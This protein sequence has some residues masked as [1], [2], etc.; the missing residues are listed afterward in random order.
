[1]VR[2][3]EEIHLREHAHHLA[4]TN[5]FFLML[6]AIPQIFYEPRTA[7]KQQLRR[8]QL[9]V[10]YAVIQQL[11]VKFG[12]CDMVSHKI[13]RLMADAQSNQNAGKDFVSDDIFF[14][15]LKALFPFPIDL[16]PNLDLIIDDGLGSHGDNFDF[17]DAFLFE[18]SVLDWSFDDSQFPIFYP[19]G[20]T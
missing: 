12:G 18:T 16:S 14:P 11:S 8:E 3:Y 20:N 1:M 7:E 4:S 17:T 6:A 10:I 19:D 15:H 2:L 13:S 9:D 5:G